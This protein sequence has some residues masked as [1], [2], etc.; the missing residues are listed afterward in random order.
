MQ[1]LSQSLFHSQG[2]SCWKSEAYHCWLESWA[3]PPYGSC[4]CPR[5]TG[6]S[7][8]CKFSLLLEIIWLTTESS[9]C[10]CSAFGDKR[11]LSQP[12]EEGWPG[13]DLPARCGQ[14]RQRGEDNSCSHGWQVSLAWF[15]P[16]SIA[17]S[18]NAVPFSRTVY[19]DIGGSDPERAA[20]PCVAAYV[21]EIFKSTCIKVRLLSY[22][23]QLSL[24]PH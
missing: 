19:K 21:S 8:H 14:S 23:V 7:L 1:T 16:E 2:F 24:F 22:L 11:E 15:L 5:W 4:Y 3:F 17:S 6:C 18:W 10:F 12:S 9:L 20:A 13:G